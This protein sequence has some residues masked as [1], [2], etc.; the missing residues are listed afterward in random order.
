M[1]HL[2]KQI[3]AHYPEIHIQSDFLKVYIALE[4]YNTKYKYNL[5]IREMFPIEGI[6]L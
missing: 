5:P 6:F 2:I 4:N 3:Q 1:F